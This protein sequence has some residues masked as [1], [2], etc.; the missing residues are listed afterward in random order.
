MPQG[1]MQETSKNTSS[2]QL[3]PEIQQAWQGIL[4]Q[5]QG[6]PNQ[7]PDYAP[8]FA[9]PT[10]PYLTQA[11]QTA[12]G[13]RAPDYMNIRTQLG[14]H[15]GV[16]GTQV[17]SPYDVNIS[18]T[19]NPT[20]YQNTQFAA[21]DAK[22]EDTLAGYRP[23]MQ[24]AQIAGHGFSARDYNFNA[25]QVRAQQ[26][27]QAEKVQAERLA[28]PERVAAERIANPA[29]DIKS[30]DIG[31]Q[32]R[33]TPQQL[34]QYQMQRPENVTARDVATNAFI[35]P[36][37]RDQYMSP[38]MAEVVKRQQAD[39]QRLFEEQLVQTGGQAASAGAFGGSRQAVL[40]GAMRRDLSN[41]Q[42][43]IAAQGFQSA[44]ENAQQQF[45]RDRAANMQ[46][47]QLN[48]AAG[49]QAGL[50]NQQMG[51]GTNQANL[52][53][54]LSQQELGAQQGLRAQELNQNVNLQ[55][56]LAN[57]QA[58][59]QAQGLGVN[60]SLQAQMANQQYGLQAALANQAA[61]IDVGKANQAAALQAALANQQSYADIAKANQAAQLQGDISNQGA[62][63]Q[64][65]LE[66][67]RLGSSER[68]FLGGL[69]NQMNM[70]QA[71]LTQGANQL[72]TQLGFDALK[73]R[74][75]GNLQA[76]LAN[77]GAQMDA[78]KMAEQSKQFGASMGENQAQFGANLN[79]ETQKQQQAIMNDII[80]SNLAATGLASNIL[81]QE[82][83]LESEQ[84][85]Q[86]LAQNAQLGNMGLAQAGMDQQA[87]QNAFNYW[88]M[89][90]QYPM[91]HAQQMMGLVNPLF[92]L[93][94]TTQ[95]GYTRGPSLLQQ[96]GGLAAAGAGIASQFVV[97][98]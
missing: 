35:D 19:Y 47:Q 83:G 66:G 33:I 57:Q 31:A 59:L 10:N 25:D 26:I 34:Q 4:N 13:A 89:Q 63:L 20:A 95:T 71:E 8:G 51:F 56:E 22:W 1:G 39:A 30:F 16:A 38:Y 79:L 23:D 18:N 58:R 36:G 74:Y 12:A 21:P 61:G 40:E 68:Q 87:Q 9:A 62:N 14:E 80:R 27:A 17:R 37:V 93:G 53:A 98:H 50:A 96:I 75:G 46:A 52:Q 3:P 72:N 28:N 32:E 82:A 64:A 44:F 7:L 76:G 24:A 90:Q 92:Q 11:Q 88:L 55:R 60:T 70:A 97:P 2:I 94:T 48:Q 29:A 42:G 43:N 65:Q 86:N 73:T 45:E 85:N 67:A 77:Q 5:A 78:L 49:L 15:S 6:T 84:F 54:L 41:Q 81:G 69:N 91:M